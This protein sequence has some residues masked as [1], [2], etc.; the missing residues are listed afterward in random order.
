M[1]AVESAVE[2]SVA[3]AGGVDVLC[4]A[5]LIIIGFDR[6]VSAASDTILGTW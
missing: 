4:I 6:G 3:A 2:G 5:F 1:R